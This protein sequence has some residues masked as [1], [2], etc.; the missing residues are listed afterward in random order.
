MQRFTDLR[1]WRQAHELVVIIYRL[2]RGYPAAE[3][4]GLVDQLRRA[5]A[6]VPTNIAEGSKRET[7][8]DYARFL[9]LAEGSLAEIQYLL[10]LS[11]DLG[12]GD[13]EVIRDAQARAEV[14]GR[15]LY[16]LRSTV[17][18]RGKRS[19]VNR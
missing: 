16:R 15:M 2:T 11:S 14:V 10:I 3:R 8:A 9:N 19:T 7:R 4:F 5:A 13:A 6:S 1:V 12:L 17:R 18:A